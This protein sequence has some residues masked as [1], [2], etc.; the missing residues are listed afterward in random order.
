MAGSGGP[1]WPRT[2]VLGMS[3][4]GVADAHLVSAV[5]RGGGFGV[6]DLAG[7]PTRAA[8]AL[9]RVRNTSAAP[10]GV[11][12]AGGC[13][14][15]PGEVLAGPGVGAVVLGAG[16]PW[17]I[18]SVAAQSP[19]AGRIILVEVTDLDE[20][21]WAVADGADGLIARGNEAA[22]RVGEL[23]SFVLLQRLL[24][25]YRV[26]L[27]VWVCGGIGPHTAAGAVAGGAAGV[28]LDSQL[29][30]FPESSAPRR[31]REQLARAD[32]SGTV[33]VD[34][35]RVLAAGTPEEP[36]T[37]S[38]PVPFGQDAHL[39]SLFAR[40]YGTAEQA[41]RDIA[42]ILARPAQDVDPV[43]QGAPLRRTLGAD[44]AVAQGP[45]T[46][47]SDQPEF[48]GSVAE[49]GGVPFVAVALADGARTTE[50]LRRTADVV[51]DRPWGAGILGFVSDDL[52]AQQLEAIRRVRPRC[53]LI[54]GGKPGQAAR[55]EAEGMATYLHVPS[56]ILLRQYLDAGARRF[57]FEGSECGGHIGPHSSF[58][59][60][61]AQL[62]VLGGFLDEHPD[63]RV[64]VF[65]AGGV[66]DGR[67]AA[68]VAAMA[69]PVAARGA[70]V[71]VLLGTAYLF[72]E[73]AV[74]HGAITELFQRRAVEA[75]STA[76]LETAPGHLTRCLHSPFVE[77]FRTASRELHADG[78]QAQE[79][80]RRLEELNTGRL[81]VASKGIRREGA[82][83]VAVGEREQLA[84]GMYMA[85][86]VAVLREETTDIASLHRAVTEEAA[87]LL[88]DRAAQSRA[89]VAEPRREPLDVAIVGMACVF[90]G[91]PDLP[92]FWSNVLRGVD[93]VTE[94]PPERWNTEV[95]HRPPEEAEPGTTPSKWGGFLPP[96]AF[97]PL[98]FGIPPASMGSIDPSQLLSL[99]TARRALED[100]GY[101]ERAFDRVRTSV[102]FGAESGGDLADAGV[103]RA[104]LPAYLEVLPPELDEQL[105]K[106]TEDSFPGT[107]ANVIAGRIA[108]R[109]DL[110]GANYTVD[111]ACGSSLAAMDLACKE[112]VQGSS[113]MVLCGAVDLHNGINDYLM[114]ASAGALSPTGRCRPFDSAADGIALGE[115][116]ACLVL[117]RLGDAERAGDRVYA[118]VKGIGAASDGR[119]LGLTAPRPEGQHRALERAYRAAGVAPSGIG[120]IEAHGT[121]TVVGD[122]TEL[123]TLTRFFTEAGARPGGCA[124]GSVKSQIGHT[125]CAAG[126]AGVIKTA[127]SLSFGVHPPTL[128]LRQP[129]PAWDP[130][131]SPFRFTTS[132]RPWTAPRSERAAGVSAFGFGGTNFHAVLTAGPAGAAE[133][134]GMRDWDCELFLFR[135]RGARDAMGELLALAERAEL[136]LHALAATASERAEQESGSVR[137]AV[138]ASDPAELAESLRA[139]LAGE[140][141]PGLF[142]AEEDR[143]P[144]RLALLFPGQGSQ[145][146]GMLAGLF[147][148]LP[149]LRHLLDVDPAVSAVVYPPHAFDPSVAAAQFEALR[150]TRIA[151]PA[152]GIVETA[153]CELLARLEVRPDALAGH[154]Y[155]EL[156]ALSV[157]GS[158]DY[159]ALLRMSRRRAE[160][161]LEATGDDPGAMAAV[162]GS[163]VDVAVALGALDVV[164]ANHNSPEQVVI[165]G[166]T[167]AVEEAV[168]LLREKSFGVKPVPVACAF[169]SPLVAG[170][171]DG[172]A[173]AVAA[174]RV[175]PPR[176]PV[177]SNRTARPYDAVDAEQVRA[178][179]CAQIGAPVRF[180]EQIEDMYAT[181]V[182]TFVEVG[183]G[184]VLTGF[185]RSVL[186]D[187]TYSAIACDPGTGGG[188]RGLLTAAAR[189]AVAGVEVRTEW[190]FRGRAGIGEPVG[191][192]WVV[193][194]HRVRRKDGGRVPNGLLPARR[195]PIAVVAATE[196]SETTVDERERIVNEF[197][198]GS[199]EMVAAQ[200]D[201]LL[202]YLDAS[203]APAPEQPAP[204]MPTRHGAE[205][206]RVED[207]PT[208]RPSAPET[209]EEIDA[210]RVVV[211]VIGKRTGYPAELVTG[212]LDLETDL[213]IDS[214]KRTE[215]AGILL[216]E[217]GIQGGVSADEQEE[218]SR[219]RTVNSIVRWIEQR[220]GGG[221]A[222]QRLVM[223]VV[224]AAEIANHETCEVGE[225]V[226]AVVHEPSQSLLRDAVR[227]ELERHGATV[228]TSQH[229]ELPSGRFDVLLCLNPLAGSDEPVVPQVFGLLR[230]AAA[231][232]ASALLVA[233]PLA[234][235]AAP[236]DHAAGLRGLLR[237]VCRE[238]DD[239]A[240]KLVEL[241]V[242]EPAATARE[243]VRELRTDDR[244]PVVQRRADVRT[245]FRLEPEP[246]DRRPLPEAADLGLDENSVVL[247]VGGA[248]GI[249]AR[250]ARELAA[251]TGCRVELVGRTP[252]PAAPEDTATA[253]V[254][255]PQ[256]LRRVLAADASSLAEAERQVH[257]LLARREVARTLEEI[258]ATGSPVTYHSIDVRDGAALG[259]LVKDLHTA[260]GGIDGVVH[261]AGVIDDRRM[262]EKD[263][264][265]F[266]D[267]FATKA[268]SAKVLLDALSQLGARPRF[269][270]FFGSIAAVLGN[271][272]QTDYAA[273]NDALESLGAAWSARTGNRVL[274]VHWGPWA[275]SAEH[276][277]MVSAELAREYERRGVRLIDPGDG[278]ACL[279]RELAYGTA[280]SVVYAASTW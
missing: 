66:H 247:L 215:I 135:G 54:A 68:M 216:A 169:H 193:D 42:A 173:P 198:R 16:S 186:G 237:A 204:A 10:F 205:V 4:A 5:S 110:G 184:S 136:P 163:E 75:G 195:R 275:P 69:A 239:L 161:I 243:L 119:S 51:G 170:A 148:A 85:G 248:R 112:L 96:V 201:V 241:E 250:F 59:L 235:D 108:N 221:S 6:L 230:D 29:G 91:A 31:L 99:Q 234:A 211:E 72:T 56:P 228:L 265:S 76:T 180:A 62:D 191:A 73:E 149:E 271:Q 222:V 143:D 269:V 206:E 223:R 165:S 64:E 156:V 49:R 18:R 94:V 232:G 279:L 218:L 158:Y 100:A 274:T 258:R 183:P 43:A 97:D 60:W 104:L 41:V 106:L 24:A 177:W 272:G 20:A 32:G 13:E 89:T 79:R 12:S 171:R 189:L 132:A 213:S 144:G 33:V 154:S 87:A 266:R 17:T 168:R 27:P 264:A 185:V 36:G 231:R 212:D 208:A 131:S 159:P 90:P 147:V 254:T 61:E 225:K 63:A 74:A 93:S 130:D 52:R 116:V 199:R 253:G 153:L 188:L 190:L 210:H 19:A 37:G 262:A 202:G 214:I 47:V 151:Q 101:G 30:L 220:T 46:R 105:P 92:A 150:D 129:N 23:S 3:P 26:D 157:A 176:I 125:K 268:E 102:I 123:R 270:T 78:V 155:G 192:D 181:G 127:L 141:A 1:L 162:Q 45:M 233:A 259:H 137:F 226:V 57:V 84:E 71:G 242:G 86:Q 160:S 240:G 152:L 2:R 50:L 95:Y 77:E 138:V 38:R 8:E 238:R 11:R 244:I 267:V 25:D 249:T 128:H 140:E 65:F 276:G 122:G 98:S 194:G 39:A 80:W 70:G 146:P 48:A 273:A 260:H 126:L 124:L 197:L 9:L 53:V 255:D 44:L 121:G 134:H 277:G 15:G 252:C 83:L 35:H 207:L 40:R 209:G 111:A 167:G 175:H 67:S 164:V 58:S 115:G 187:R 107:L 263:D 256:E 114:F 117:K 245:G 172:F 21:L 113:D 14:L 103:L 109:L 7:M 227:D 280:E 139:A 55:L 22:G 178:E 81:R 174:E 251:T 217:L 261:A 257:A 196:T 278:P 118:V 120:A 179:L 133:R 34:G 182:R 28:V 88:R 142:A 224:P 82:D 200:R 203:R 145:R 166:T 236:H 246:L 219:Q 229:D